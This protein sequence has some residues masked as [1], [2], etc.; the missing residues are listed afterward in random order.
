MFTIRNISQVFDKCKI[1]TEKEQVKNLLDEIG[2][3]ENVY[4][5]KVLENSCGDGNILVEIVKMYIEISLN[6]KYSLK[7]IRDGLERNII[8]YEIDESHYKHCIENLNKILER[9]NLK[10]VNW[11]IY[12]KDFLFSNEK[13]KFD[14]VIGNPPFIKYSEI[15]LDLRKILCEN[16]KSC[17]K[18]KF[19]YYFP[20]IEKGL[21]LLNNKGK[22]AYILPNS[23]FKNV[24]GKIIRDEILKYNLKIVD[25]TGLKIFKKV[26]LPISIVCCENHEEVASYIKYID[27]KNKIEKNIEKKELKKKWIF[28]TYISNKGPKLKEFIDAH[29]SIAT[30]SNN[31]FLIKD[32]YEI[33]DDHFVINNF[34]VEKKI[35]RK[36]V[37]PRSAERKK[38]EFIIFPYKK[39]KKNKFEKYEEKEFQ[40]HFPMAEKY[41][42]DKIQILNKR[43]SDKNSKWFEYG[44]NQG[45]YNSYQPKI[46][47]STIITQKVKIYFL[48]EEEIPYSG[49]CITSNTKENLEIVYRILKSNKFLEYIYSVG[50][51]TNGKSVRISPKDIL[52]Y[53]IEES[54]YEQFRERNRKRIKSNL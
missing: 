40:Q 8:A 39:N 27:V 18:G 48:S 2:Y 24:S 23:L 26:K 21:K 47:L 49:I 5:K 6:E 52:N 4:N 35:I 15:N 25:Y 17:Q 11:K 46:L 7:E 16:F 53:N 33:K 51:S 34:S 38:E 28:E 31:V 29:M 41:L 9:Y 44:R 10:P 14:Y 13:E 3:K 19:D 45:I 50:I 22:L 12:N 37:S 42:Q 20:F 36:A 32:N 1:F 43:K 30:L 54:D